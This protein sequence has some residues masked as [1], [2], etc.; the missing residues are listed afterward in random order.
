MR[1]KRSVWKGWKKQLWCHLEVN[2]GRILNCSV[3]CNSLKKELYQ[4]MVSWP[5]KSLCKPHFVITLGAL[6]F[7]DPKQKHQL[8]VVVPR[9]LVQQVL[10]LCHHGPN[11]GHYSDNRTYRS[12]CRRWWWEKMYSGAQQFSANCPECAIVNSSGCHQPPPLHPIPVQRPFQI[13]G[14]DV[15]ELPITT[16]GNK[17]VVVFQ[18]YLTKWP[19]VYAMP[20]QKAHQIARLSGWDHAILW[21]S[22][23][24]PLRQGN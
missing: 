13:V 6:H 18:D 9:H 7:M 11:G 14:V 4:R 22:R 5:R 3:F 10:D 2:R 24:A 15:M 19:M 12:L 1:I 16:K 21:C 8:W 20:D 17:Y 23:I